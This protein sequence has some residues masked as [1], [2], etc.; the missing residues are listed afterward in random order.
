MC[1]VLYPGVVR[2]FHL[3]LCACVRDGG[4]GVKER[5]TERQREREGEGEKERERKRCSDQR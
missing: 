1:L 2:T 4:R 5:E 3:E